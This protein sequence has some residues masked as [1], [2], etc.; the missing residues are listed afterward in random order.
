MDALQFAY[1]LQ[2]FAELNSQ[3]PTPEQWQS[4]REHLD[5][6][7][8]KVTPPVSPDLRKVY[9]QIN[10]PPDYSKITC[11]PAVIP[12]AIKPTAIC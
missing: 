4:I 1:W 5:T 3:Q 9:E 12:L 10:Y 8:K 7:F 6:V 2:G 11:N